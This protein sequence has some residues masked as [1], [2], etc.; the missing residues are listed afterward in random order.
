ME[1]KRDIVF[2]NRYYKISITL[3]VILKNSKT[4]QLRFFLKKISVADAIF[5]VAFGCLETHVTQKFNLKKNNFFI[6]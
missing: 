4:Y 6:F 3:I 2:K 1:K 5:C